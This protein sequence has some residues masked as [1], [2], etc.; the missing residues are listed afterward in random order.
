[1]GQ[2]VDAAMVAK[3]KAVFQWN[4]TKD[5]TVV[6]TWTVDLKNGSGSV[7]TGG[8]KEKAGCVLTL[9]DDDMQA[10]ASGKLDAMK[11]FMSGKLK[12]SGNVMLAQKLQGL[13]EASRGQVPAAHL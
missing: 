1:M 2:G 10:L 3:T 8:A 7:Y 11:A 4:I 12:V 5:G 6:A 9:S 13:F